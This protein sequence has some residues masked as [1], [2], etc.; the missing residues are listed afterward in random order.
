MKKNLT[1]FAILIAMSSVNLFA[2]ESQ[3]SQESDEF[4]RLMY[5]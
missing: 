5:F 1:I 2:Q 3:K 4:L